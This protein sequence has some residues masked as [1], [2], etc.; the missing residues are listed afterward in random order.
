MELVLIVL[1][2]SLAFLICVIAVAVLV[3]AIRGFNESD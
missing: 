1:G 2:Y 3:L